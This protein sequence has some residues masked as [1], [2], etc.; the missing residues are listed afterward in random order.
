MLFPRRC[1][2]ALVRHHRKLH[3]EP[4]PPTQ[5]SS[6]ERRHPGAL[7]GYMTSLTIIARR[8]GTAAN[9]LTT[10]LGAAGSGGQIPTAVPESVPK[11][12]IEAAP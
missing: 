2:Q 1:N 8:I 11:P 4:K 3:A 12:G 5:V 7:D 9:E 6:D 10:A